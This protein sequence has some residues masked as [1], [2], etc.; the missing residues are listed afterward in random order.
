MIR[1]GWDRGFGE[2]GGVGEVNKCE[3]RKE[4]G[5]GRRCGKSS[6]EK[7]RAVMAV[8]LMVAVCQSTPSEIKINAK[9]PNTEFSDLQNTLKFLLEETE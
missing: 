9:V 2:R 5:R 8:P 3:S 4:M 1:D 7:L 6:C